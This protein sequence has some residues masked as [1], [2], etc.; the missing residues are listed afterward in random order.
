[1]LYRMSRQTS[2]VVGG[3]L[4]HDSR[5]PAAEAFPTTVDGYCNFMAGM[6]R[7]LGQW[8]VVSMPRQADG[9]VFV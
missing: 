7:L 1:M 2:V 5:V 9:K 3:P 8:R 6:R 4:G